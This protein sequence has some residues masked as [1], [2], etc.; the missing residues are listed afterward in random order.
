M[1]VPLLHILPPASILAQAAPGG[2]NVLRGTWSHASLLTSLSLL[3]KPNLLSVFTTEV[4][5][6]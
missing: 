2:V 6:T 4:L 5:Y 3:L 1:H